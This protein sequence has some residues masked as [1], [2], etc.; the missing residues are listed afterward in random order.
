MAWASA[1]YKTI[2]P[3][4]LGRRVAALPLYRMIGGVVLHELGEV[5]AVTEALGDGLDVGAE[6]IRR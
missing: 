2:Y 6:T 4:Y 1:Y 5:R 3:Y